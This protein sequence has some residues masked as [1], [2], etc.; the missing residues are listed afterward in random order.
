MIEAKL[1]ERWRRQSLKAGLSM[2]LMLFTVGLFAQVKGVIRDANTNE[3]LI[4]ASVL[5]KGTTT[6]TVTGLDGDFIINAKQGD[7]LQLSYTGY[8]AAEA[9]VGSDMTVNFNL[10]P[11]VAIDEVVVTG[12]QELRKR[13]VTGAV[14]VLDAKELK[15]L[16]GSSFNQ[17]LAGR[18]S[19]V[20][21]S[22]SGNPGEGANI[23]VRGISSF[24][25][26]DPLYII[27]GV[28]TQD[29]YQTS[30]N[31]NDIETMQIL[32][33]GA[34]SAIYGSRASNGVIVITTKQGKSGK[35]KV[36]YDGSIGFASAVK[37]FDQVL[38]TDSKT[39]VEFIRRRYA[40]DPASI[41]PYAKLSSLPK[42]IQPIADNVDPATYDPLTNPISVTNQ[43]GTNWWKEMSRTAQIHDHNINISGGNESATFNISAGILAQEGLLLYNYFDRGTVRANSSFKVRNGIRIGENFTLARTQGVGIGSIGGNNNE[44]SVFGDILKA[45]P[46]IPV[47]DIKGNPGS[48]LQ[49]GLSNNDNPVA[50]LFHNKD[51]TYY[52]NRIF[53]NLYAEVD[54][55]KGLTLR[56]SYGV[57]LGTGNNKAFTFPNPYRSEGNKT[58]NSFNENFSANNNWT[59]T[60][61]ARYHTVIGTRHDITLLAGQE[62]ISSDFRNISGSLANYFTQ[63]VNAWYLQTALADPGSRQVS[64]SGGVSK[65]AS[66]FGKADYSF[67][68]KYLI[69]GSIRRD[70]SSKFLSGVRYGV[71]PSVSIGWRVSNESFM[72]DI[73]WLNDLKLRA[74]YG[75]VGNQNIRNYSYASIYGGGVGSTFYDISGKNGSPSTGYALRSYGN[76]DIVWENNK[77]KNIGIDAHLFNSSVSVVLDVYN[78]ATDGLLY[79][80][81]LPG[82]AGAADAPFV[83]VGGMKNTGFDLGLGYRANITSDL[84]FRSHLTLSHYKNEITKISS[85]VKEFYPSDNLTERLLESST[86]F[87]NRIGYPISSFRGYQVD[88][89]ITTEAEK[90]RQVGS[91]IGGLRF[92]DIN[93]DGTIND[94][95]LTILGS[96]HPKLTAGLNLGFEMKNWDLNAFI[97]GSYGNKIFNATK[98]QTVYGNFNSNPQKDVVANDGKNGFPKINALDASLKSSSSFFVED[99]SY[100]RLGN[101][102]LGYNFTTGSIKGISSL[103]IYAQAQ[104]L[105]TITKY[106]GVDPAV[107][108]FNIGN[109]GGTNDLRTGYDNG[110]YPTNKIITLGV[111]LGL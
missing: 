98:I 16:K 63:D 72:K 111:N 17:Q 46:L 89:L 75:E 78:R 68:D 76:P 24:G 26:N 12:Y 37:G 107:S 33:D 50:R 110:N 28:P 52:N 7:V 41:P 42:Y 40:A 108:S 30:I 2:M 64:S 69:S 44:Q 80:P 35:T 5:V 36:T 92:R 48:N 60:N 99:G 61:T 85:N 56:T 39:F 57:D 15:G 71:F 11:G 6:G 47:Y 27:D 8:T 54:L 62:A 13:D 102:Q 4:G 93:G 81:A 104:N 91:Q 97:F 106:S 77:T 23:R 74:S 103:R 21:V 90:T 55:I 84:K 18:V 105:L 86:A 96:P 95:D 49:Q 19:G 73:P 67:N 58:A 14:A 43:S 65:L 59:L 53:G 109:N 38:N 25:S 10:Q 29:K 22:A 51:N 88:G 34:A 32:K 9:T 79:N 100:T 94:K 45:N 31:P 70:G 83:N 101:L 20:T 1:L 82:T 3:P 66:L 87:V